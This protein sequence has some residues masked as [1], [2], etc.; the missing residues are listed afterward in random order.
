M[1]IQL[2]ILSNRLIHFIFTPSLVHIHV[3]QG[4][5]RVAL[6]ASI[7][8]PS[9]THRDPRSAQCVKSIVGSRSHGTRGFLV[10]LKLDCKLSLKI[11]CNLQERVRQVHNGSLY[12]INRIGI[13][14]KHFG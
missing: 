7:N 3:T 4:D 13:F 6:P 9:I 8:L 11:R 1:K 10:Q 5:T 12:G 2:Q 14:T